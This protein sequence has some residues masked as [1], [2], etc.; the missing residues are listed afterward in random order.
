MGQDK[1]RDW[2]DLS[3]AEKA[4]QYA[5]RM[6]MIGE[7]VADVR[8]HRMI[9]CEGAPL[10]PGH[11]AAEKIE[12][13]PPWQFGDFVAS[14]LARIA[15][16]DGELETLRTQLD[17]ERARVKTLGEARLTAEKEADAGWA[18]YRQSREELAATLRDA[19]ADGAP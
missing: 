17:Q 4:K 6:V 19:R 10:C 8:A 11:E 16:Q 14:C 7:L 18:A 15:D 3:P 9:E 13:I 1:G 12:Q 5:E 2:F